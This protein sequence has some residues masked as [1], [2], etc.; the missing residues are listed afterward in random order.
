MPLYM[1]T[2]GYK[3]EVWAGLMKS[4]ENR[5]EA[6]GR[7]LEGAGCK[8]HGLWYAFGDSDGFALFEA[9]SEETA[10]GMSIAI[11]ASGAFRSVATTPVMTQDQVLQ[12]LGV[13]AEAN[14]VA[15]AQAVHA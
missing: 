3:P 1:I 8:L 5:E 9:P 15:P 11:A 13:A 12:A 7:V 10:A 2:F 6:V 14:Y 4:P